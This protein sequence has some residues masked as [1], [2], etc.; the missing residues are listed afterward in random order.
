[1]ETSNLEESLA[2][3]EQAASCVYEALGTGH[4]ERVYHRAMEVHLRSEGV[5]YDSHVMVPVY[6]RGLQV[7]YGEAD[8]IVFFPSE[9]IIVELKA[10]SHAIKPTERA[11]LERYLSNW[12]GDAA[13]GIVVN[14]RQP[15][16]H[17]QSPSKVDTLRIVLRENNDA[18]SSD[19]CID[20]AL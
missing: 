8:L 4:T 1:M 18:K 3:I 20:E 14:F 10:T 19:T 15:S 5:V 7:G 16:S 13:A 12:P 6:Y 9:I 2:W 11:Q 17:T